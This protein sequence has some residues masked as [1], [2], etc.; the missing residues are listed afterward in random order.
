MKIRTVLSLDNLSK[1]TVEPDKTIRAGRIYPYDG[2][3]LRVGDI[4]ENNGRYN[5]ITGINSEE[6]YESETN[7]DAAIRDSLPESEVEA[8]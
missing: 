3:E 7:P 2:P 1:V 8:T 6:Y 5:R 4:V